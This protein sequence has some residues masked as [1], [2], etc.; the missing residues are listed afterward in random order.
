MKIDRKTTTLRGGDVIDVLERP[1]GNYGAPLMPRKKKTKPTKEQMIQVNLLNKA[2]VCRLKMLSYMNYDDWFG[3]WTYEE[4]ERP[5][6]MNT[7]LKHF[8]EAMRK[9][10][11]FYKKVGYECFWFRNI[12]LGTKGGWHIHFVFK[13]IKGSGDV[14]QN[15]W[16]HGGTY[17]VKIRKSKYFSEDFTELA[18]YITKSENTIEYKKD[19]TPAKPKIKESNYNT[20]RNMPLPDPKPDKLVRWKK[21][22]K[23]KKGYYIINLYEGRNPATE[24]PYRR[25]TM[26]RIRGDDENV[27]SEYIFGNLA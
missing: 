16:T 8:Q 27:R 24:L 22:V 9:I 23:P 18:N 13:N 2:R 20:S 26:I 25:Y 12:Q 11:P 4:S 17:I 19:G 14:I 6:D 21:E 10:R 1:E 15:A 7:A 5:P 3:T